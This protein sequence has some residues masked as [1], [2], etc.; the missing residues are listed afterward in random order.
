[1]IASGK[2][3]II[4]FVFFKKQLGGLAAA[5]QAQEPGFLQDLVQL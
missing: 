5:D 4:E 2:L 3:I 1:M